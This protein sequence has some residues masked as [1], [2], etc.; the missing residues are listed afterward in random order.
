MN[1]LPTPP[2]TRHRSD[3][4]GHIA[5]LVALCNRKV[6]KAT[7]GNVRKQYFQ[8][9]T[10]L[11]YEPLRPRRESNPRHLDY[12]GTASCATAVGRSIADLLRNAT[13]VRPR[14]GR[15]NPI[16]TLKGGGAMVRG[17]CPSNSLWLEPH[18]SRPSPNPVRPVALSAECGASFADLYLGTAR[19]RQVRARPRI[20]RV[21]WIALRVFAWVPA[22]PRGYHRRAADRRRALSLLPSDFDRARRTLLPVPGR[23]ERVFAGGT[24]GFLLSSAGSTDRRIRAP[25]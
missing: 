25:R 21:G 16:Q 15:A 14:S 8:C 12:E 13:R 5:S 11:S 19:N 7:A 18:G 6:R 10:Q 23:T 9:S 3:G 22:S 4:R 2:S 1:P 20:R 24:E 17:A